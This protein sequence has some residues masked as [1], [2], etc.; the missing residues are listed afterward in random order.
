[1][2]R[3][4]AR[5]CHDHTTL[6]SRRSTSL[7]RHARKGRG[8]AR[9]DCS[10]V[11][12][13]ELH[14][15]ITASD[16]VSLKRVGRHAVILLIHVRRIDVLAEQGSGVI[17]VLELTI[18]PSENRVRLLARPQQQ[19]TVPIERAVEFLRSEDL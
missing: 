3:R 13:G 4:K 9:L 6:P 12:A 2:N 8:I 11:A 14:P 19:C 5:A 16:S 1:M 7:L 17:F 18:G 10:N 15:I